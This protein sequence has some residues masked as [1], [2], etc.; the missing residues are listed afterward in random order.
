MIGQALTRSLNWF[1]IH[2]DQRM[3]L[4]HFYVILLAG[5]LALLGTTIKDKNFTVEFIVGATLVII[6]YIF[7]NL[8]R[9]TAALVKDAERALAELDK[10]FATELELEAIELV[11]AAEKGKGAL[12]YRQSFNHLFL[13]GCTIGVFFLLHATWYMVS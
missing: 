11:A 6:T 7:K 9:R 2:A 12:S 13:L 1:Q 8:D 3:K 5:S 4:M 10:R